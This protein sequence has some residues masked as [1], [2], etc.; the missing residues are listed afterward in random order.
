MI[1]IELA[2]AEAALLL[3]LA[4]QRFQRLDKILQPTS[5]RRMFDEYQASVSAVSALESAIKRE[6]SNASSQG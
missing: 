1:V 4:Q 2:D 3:K 6:E 5:T